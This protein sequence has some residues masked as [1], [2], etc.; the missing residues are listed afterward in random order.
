MMRR[1]EKVSE[2]ASNRHKTLKCLGDCR[3]RVLE[4]RVVFKFQFH[5]H[6][7]DGCHDQNLCLPIADANGSRCQHPCR[8]PLWKT[9]LYGPNSSSIPKEEEFTEVVAELQVAWEDCR[10]ETVK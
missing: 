7:N 9:N 1:V 10:V 4:V 8:I 6:S 3:G 5:N 2:T